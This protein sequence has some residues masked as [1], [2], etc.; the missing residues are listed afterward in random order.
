LIGVGVFFVVVKPVNKLM[1]MRK[2]QPD[3]E[4]P[5]VQCGE[6]LSNIPAG[7]RRCAFC[8]SLQGSGARG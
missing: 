1:E 3:V 7:A 8:T 5:T 6:C 4:S 2:T